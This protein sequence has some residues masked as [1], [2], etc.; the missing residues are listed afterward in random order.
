MRIALLYPPPW[1]VLPRGAAGVDMAGD[2]ATVPYG[3]LSLAAEADRAGHQ[4]KTVNLS[5]FAWEEVEGLVRRLDADVYG[6]TCF[7]GNRRG[8]LLTADCIREHHPSAHIVVGGPH[9][10]AMPELTLRHCGA[11]D[12]VVIGEGERTFL[13]LIDRLESGRDPGGIAGTAWRAVGTI[14]RA[15]PRERIGELDSLA[16]VHEQ[17]AHYMLLTS[18]GCPG[19]CTFCGS[20]AMWQR[21]V[22]FHREQY[23]LDSLEAMLTRLPVK[24]IAIKDDTFTVNRSRA[25]RICEGIVDRGLNFLWSCDTRADVLDEE[26]L[27][28]M[29]LAGCQQIS[30]GVESGSPEILASIRK[31]TT[32]EQVIE[33]T[34]QARKYGLQ[35]RFYM[36]VG[37]R[38]ESAKTFQ[39]SLDLLMSARPNDFI[40]SVL[41]VYPGT[42]E[43]ELLRKRGRFLTA[44]PTGGA[45][46]LTERH[47]RLTADEFFT[48][49]FMQ[50]WAFPDTP[51]A[52]A[53]AICRWL[54]DR[55]GVQKY[56]PLT[57][58]ECEAA[59][60]R[61][62]GLHAAHL[63]L[64][65]AYTYAGRLDAAERHARLA[66]ELGYPVP[67]IA[68][69]Y[70]ACL[71]AQR[72]DLPAAR[73]HLN[74]AMQ[75]PSPHPM[76]AANYERLTKWTEAGG[77]E[78]GRPLELVARHDFEII[79]EPVQP[80]RPGP[81]PADFHVW[82]TPA[83]V[84]APA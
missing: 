43:F 38:G 33:V 2:F 75:Q 36:M 14:Q 72:G 4:V 57:V 9:V 48:G 71:A 49:D 30:L 40:F 16:P 51:I 73:G 17:F 23:V 18:R 20:E 84:G 83:G 3:L 42:E 26:L 6:L 11:I 1:K 53:K 61:L 45:A 44:R 10:S 66:M 64:A 67:A 60:H 79:P 35:V 69:N 82:P 76:I 46:E 25:L 27:L 54:A 22:R 37:N 19:Q 50:L 77:A 52:E 7:T 59:L 80:V 47:G 56:R 13:E 21:K 29:R 32:P 41:S 28:A 81:I 58:A 8:V 24:M 31:N 15:A 70:L 68:L 74:E 62:P 65:A 12:T 34:Q 39:Q 63:D 5:S 78:A 55:Q